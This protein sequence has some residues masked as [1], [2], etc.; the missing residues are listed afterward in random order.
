MKPLPRI[1]NNLRPLEGIGPRAYPT[2][3]IGPNMVLSS[4]KW[5]WEPSLRRYQD[6]SVTQQ[7]EIS[8]PTQSDA[9]F[10][11]DL[12]DFDWPKDCLTNQFVNV[13]VVET[14]YREI[15]P[16]SNNRFDKNFDWFEIRSAV[17]RVDTQKL[18][19]LFARLPPYKSKGINDLKFI[20][21]PK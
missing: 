20:S 1:I 9:T 12:L 6:E 8:S 14:L 10:I 11:V 3:N 18:A 5:G 15:M 16:Y 7:P 21:P 2:T 17:F 4:I 13:Q 19:S